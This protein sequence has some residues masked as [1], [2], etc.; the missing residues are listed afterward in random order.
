MSER[1]KSKSEES[2]VLKAWDESDP[3]VIAYRAKMD[4]LFGPMDPDPPTLQEIADEYFSREPV[5]KTIPE[6]M[7]DIDLARGRYTIPITLRAYPA[8]AALIR[9]SDLKNTLEKGKK[10]KQ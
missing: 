2:I 9:T 6:E 8:L 4:E 10:K 5:K 1:K 7:L 3:N